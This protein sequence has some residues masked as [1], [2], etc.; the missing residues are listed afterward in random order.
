MYRLLIVD[1]EEIIT[2]GLYEVFSSLMPEQLDVCKAYSGKEALEWMSRTRIDIVLTDIA[3][4]GLNGLE[5]IDRVRAYWSRC[6]VIFLTGHSNFE[7]TYQAIQMTNVRYLLKT[8]GFDKVI[9][10]VMEVIKEIQLNN[11]ESQLLKQSRE[12]V[13][14]YEF[15]AQGDFMRLLLQN[16]KAICSDREALND[17]FKKLNM[18]LDPK[19]NVLMVLSRLT[20]PKGKTYTERCDILSSV[21]AKWDYHLSDKT[22]SIGITDK[23]GD[24]L[25]FIQPIPN[26]EDVVEHHLLRYLEGTLE[27]IQKE[28]LTSLGITLGFTVSGRCCKWEAIAQNYERLHRVQQLKMGDDIPVILWDYSDQIDE[29]SNNEGLVPTHKIEVI[30]A[31]LEANRAT[32]FLDDLEELVASTN[33]YGNVQKTI[34][35]YFSIALVLYS[36]INRQGWNSRIYNYEMLLR[37]DDHPSMK[38]GFNF[39]RAI[40]EGIIKIKQTDERDRSSQVID[41]ICQYIERNLG[42]DL[43]LVRLAETFYFNPSY[44]SYFFKQECGSNLSEYIDKCRIRK[45]KE[46]LRDRDLKIR[47]IAANVGYTSAHSFTRFFK[48]VTGMTPKE[49]RENVLVS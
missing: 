13:Y 27:L 46:L 38:E 29:N 6:K 19:K 5:L 28:C 24:M 17:D 1:D 49:Y 45:A 9:D 16:S 33:L 10:T 47:E 3:M 37:L 32:E 23:F 48:K 2:D 42:E 20:F 31:H 15:M 21:R 43:S 39:L 40:A 34:E 7:Y 36:Y 25:W 4:P 44:L 14:A 8:E 41:R 30:A 26:A 12:Q 35:T 22:C 18:A 11:F